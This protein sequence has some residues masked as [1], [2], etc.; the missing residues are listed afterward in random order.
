VQISMDGRGRALNHVFVERL[1]RS[2]KD[3][4]VSQ[5]DD[6]TVLDARHGLARYCTCYNEERLPSGTPLR[7]P[8]VG[9]CG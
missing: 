5:R 3:E 7:T 6:H 1:W 4:E 2:V 9:Y 8:A